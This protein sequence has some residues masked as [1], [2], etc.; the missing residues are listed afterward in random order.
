MHFHYLSAVLIRLLFLVA[1]NM[2][3]EEE[4]SRLFASFNNQVRCHTWV[5]VVYMHN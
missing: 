5:T 3:F 4:H 1:T 2:V